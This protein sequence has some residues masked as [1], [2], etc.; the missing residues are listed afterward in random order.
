MFKKYAEINR[1]TNNKMRE[2]HPSHFQN[3]LQ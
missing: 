1:S 3:K 2:K